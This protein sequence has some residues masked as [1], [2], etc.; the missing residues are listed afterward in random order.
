GVAELG[1]RSP[2]DDHD[3]ALVYKLLYRLF[4]GDEKAAAVALRAMAEQVQRILWDH[5]PRVEAL[6]ASV[7]R[8]QLPG[9]S[10]DNP[11]SRL[12]RAELEERVRE[13]EQKL[14]GCT[15]GAFGCAVVAPDVRRE[16]GRRETA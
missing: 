7:A 15:C 14:A 5:W 13:L 11:L 16:G 6:G 10:N 1:R 12:T 9:V 8:L 4:D 2:S 3:F